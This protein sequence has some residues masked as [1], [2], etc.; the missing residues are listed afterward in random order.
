MFV[1]SKCEIELDQDH[2]CPSCGNRIKTQDGVLQFLDDHASTNAFGFQWN[3][4]AKTQLDSHS[5]LSISGDRLFGVSSWDT[6]LHGQVILEAGSGAGRFTEILAKTG[7]LLYTFDASSATKANAERHGALK[8][9]HVF[10]S[11]IFD[12]PFKDREF[13][14]VICLGVLQH[15]KNPREAFRALTKQ[16]RPG[17]EIVI[18]VYRKDFKAG[19]QWKYV[20]RSITRRMNQERLYKLVHLSVNVLHIPASMARKVFG[21][22]GARLFPI[23]TYGHLDLSP[24]LA[25]EW[26]VLDTFD[27]YAPRYD[28]PQSEEDVRRWF[29][30]LCFESIVVENGPNGVI[31]RGVKPE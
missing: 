24:E 15:T 30:E 16:V 9:V 31:G 29:E 4:H 26:A 7:A 23:L 1:C 17:G 6:D 3:E 28:L 27:M 14:K 20:L 22:M 11:S 25:K 8:N 2:W 13:D 12:L 5:G 10:R 18:D 21:R 19:L